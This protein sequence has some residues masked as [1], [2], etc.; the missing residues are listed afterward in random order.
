MSIDLFVHKSL[1]YSVLR[2]CRHGPGSWK[3]ILNDFPMDRTTVD[4]KDKWRNILKK[5]ARMKC[6]GYDHAKIF[7]VDFAPNSKIFPKQFL[8]FLEGKMKSL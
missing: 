5:L 1:N 8:T 4:L 7:L 6:E 3:Q 2:Y